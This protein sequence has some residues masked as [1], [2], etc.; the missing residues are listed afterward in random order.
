MENEVDLSI[1]SRE[2]TGCYLCKGKGSLLA[3]LLM[4]DL[5]SRQL[6]IALVFDSAIHSVNN[7]LHDG[8]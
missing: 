8:S 7:D 6:A 5:G 1:G 3:H 2:R 4:A